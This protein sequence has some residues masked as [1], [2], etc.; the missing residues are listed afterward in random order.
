M[1]FKTGFRGVAQ[2]SCCLN[3]AVF[4]PEPAKNRRV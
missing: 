4:D 1:R 3:S 2:S